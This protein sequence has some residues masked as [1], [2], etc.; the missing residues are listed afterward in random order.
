M[1]TAL[2]VIDVQNTL[3]QGPWA[4]FDVVATVTRIN[5]VI[6]H[7]RN[8]GGTVIFIQHEEAHEAMRFASP[9]W[10]L[11]EGLEVLSGDL[12]L[13]KTA[14]DAFFKT[15]LQ[16][17]L[18]A[19]GIDQVVIC[20]MQSEYCVNA[21]VQGALAQGLSVTVVADGHSTLDNGVLSAEQIIRHHN[22]TMANLGNFGP[23][24]RVLPA[25][26]VC[27]GLASTAIL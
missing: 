5:T 14:C 24:I 26:E 9:G 6:R 23:G 21:T 19:R 20:G 3:C 13:R 27:A 16:A 17:L 15:E 1:A 10:Q 7:T 11:Y 8:T 25:A 4:V 22:A 2:L 12:R 18:S